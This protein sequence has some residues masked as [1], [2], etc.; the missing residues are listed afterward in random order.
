MAAVDKL[1]SIPTI[2][3]RGVD[4]YPELSRRWTDLQRYLQQYAA[5]HGHTGGADGPVISAGSA[6][7]ENYTPSWTTTGTAPVVGNGTLTGRF[8]QISTTVDFKIVLTWGSTT[9]GG[10]NPWLFDLPKDA[11]SSDWAFAAHVLEDGVGNTLAMGQLQSGVSIFQ[12][13]AEPGNVVDV[14]VPHTWGT[15]DRLVITG[16]YESV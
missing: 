14:T 13:V 15:V 1:F 6:S 4:L 10:T 9:T 12:V 2:V 16:T 3:Q 8:R 7:W 5:N 11:A